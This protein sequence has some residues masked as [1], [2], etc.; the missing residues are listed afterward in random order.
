M[1]MTQDKMTLLS[2]IKTLKQEVLQQLEAIEERVLEMEDQPVFT[3]PP[4]D[5]WFTARELGRHFGISPGT[6]Y[7]WVKKGHIPQGICFGPRQTRWKL[8]DVEAFLRP[9][10]TVRNSDRRRGRP[11]K[12]RRKEDFYSV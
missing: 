10:K 6:I 8:S 3:Q 2:C 5:K 9:E 1:I 12:V 11:S 7:D 4:D